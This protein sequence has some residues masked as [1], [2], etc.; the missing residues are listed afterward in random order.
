MSIVQ[1]Q[2]RLSHHGK[3]KA[4]AK[5]GRKPPESIGFIALILMMFIRGFLKHVLSIQFLF[6]SSSS[7]NCANCQEAW[8]HSGV[9]NCMVFPGRHQYQTIHIAL[10]PSPDFS[11][12]KLCEHAN[13]GGFNTVKLHTYCERICPVN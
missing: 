13:M 6:S 10:P 1:I 12:F 9:S 11:L 8:F 5:C 3:P 4:W 7:L 2:N